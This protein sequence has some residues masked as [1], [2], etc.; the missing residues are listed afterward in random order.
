M[1]VAQHRQ[2]NPLVPMAGRPAEEFRDPLA[3]EAARVTPGVDDTP[4]IQYALEALTKERDGDSSQPSNTSSERRPFLP[5]AGRDQAPQRSPAM[6]LQPA[7]PIRPAVSQNDEQSAPLL[8]EPAVRP[9]SPRSSMSTLV[10]GKG[11]GNLFPQPKQALPDAWEPVDPVIFTD[12]REK[13]N[14]PL[15][16]KPKILRTPSMTALMILCMIMIAALIFSVVY[17]QRH[18]G[19]CDYGETIYSGQYFLFRVVPAILGAIILFWAQCNVTTMLRMR[20]FARLAARTRTARQDAL[21]DDLYPTSFLRPQLVGS[22]QVWVPN[23]ITWLMYFSLPLQSCLFTPVFVDGRWKWAT[24]QGVAWTLVALYILMLAAVA[25]ELTCWL[26]GKTGVVWDPR[27]IADVVALIANSNT[28]ADYRQTE[29]LYSREQLKQVLYR[30]R[31]DKLAYWGWA[32]RDRPDDLWY[33][34][35]HHEQWVDPTIE[36]EVLDEKGRPRSNDSRAY[37]KHSDARDPWGDVE[38]EGTAMQPR[39]RYRHLPFCLKNLPLMIFIVLG[40]LL[41]VALFLVCFIPQTRLTVEG[42]LPRLPSA[43]SAPDAGAFSAA[44]FL[45]SFLPALLGMFLFVA[46]QDLDLHLR[47][48]QPWAELSDPPSGGARPESSMLADYA[49]CYPLQAALHAIRNRHWR[50]ALISLMSTLFVFIPILAGGMFLAL[51]PED[52]VVRVFPQ[53]PLLAVTL[54]LL[55]LYWLSLVS[56]F[57][58]RQ[59]FRLPHGVTCLAEMISFVANDDCVQDEAFQGMIRNKTTLVGKLGVDRRDEDKPRWTLCTGGGGSKDDRLGVRRVRRF[60]ERL[61]QDPAAARLMGF[62]RTSIGAPNSPEGLSPLQSRREARRS[63]RES[64]QASP[65]YASPMTRES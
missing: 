14:P 1:A 16:F 34:L 60:T 37:P 35:G 9:T 58:R 27:S 63:G 41:L 8:A 10:R 47:I 30:R 11:K 18:S 42:F 19:L 33:G 56:L 53:V 65:Q 64:A 7:A 46:F 23:L 38:L 28:L 17:S 55:V 40:L 44:D 20:P 62:R 22:W 5:N 26:R 48:L 49:A 50:A 3:L 43:P 51:T 31:E 4:Y 52:N 32:D 21:F 15:I 2:V 29:I 61:A 25:I 6:S 57:P 24:V 59:A 54:T 36:V 39:V 13:I 45:Y 12:G